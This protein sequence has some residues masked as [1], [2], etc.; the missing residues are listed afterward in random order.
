MRRPGKLVAVAVLSVSAQSGFAW[1]QSLSRGPVLVGRGVP[2]LG[3]L[4]ATSRDAQSAQ[5]SGDVLGAGDQILLTIADLDEVKNLSVRISS[6]G[7]LDL[8]LV[9]IVAAGGMSVPALRT[10]LVAL[11]SK[12]ITAPQLSLQVTSSQTR[13]VS[14]LGEVNTPN[15][16][17][18][19]GP[20]TLLAAISKAGG[21][22]P[23]AGPQVI[24]TR[25]ASVGTIPLP[26]VALS[27]AGAYYRGTVVLDDLMAEKK[28]E[29]NILLLPGDVVTVPKGSLVYVIGNVKRSGGFPLRSGTVSLI[30]ALSLAE[31]LAPN[32]KSQNAKILRRTGQADKREEIP[33]DINRVLA[34]KQADPQLIANDILFV[35]SSNAKAGFR[36]ATE[37]I[38]QVTTGVLIYR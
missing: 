5:N 23:D 35:P 8:P 28:P 38:L 16:Q 22:R 9:G 1:C 20:L 21:I 24:V 10:T 7:S 12:Y 30:E 15:V 31:G 13:T 18:L 33:V 34:G 19:T 25:R 17:E 6:D 29:D 4:V 27:D 3:T 14:V 11:Y 37:A 36:R 32:A 26:T 2:V